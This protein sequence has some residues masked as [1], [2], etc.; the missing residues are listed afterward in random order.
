M[1][2]RPGL[3]GVLGI[4]DEH[5]ARR[6]ADLA[7]RLPDPLAPLARIAYN[8]RW[9]WYPGGKDVFSAID[10]GRWKLCGENPVRL[11]QEASGEELARA[12]RDPDLLARV[13]ALEEAFAADLRR[14]ALGPVGPERP[15]AFL[16]AEYAV[17]Q[18]LPVYSG[19]LGA[20]AGDVLKEASDRA[21]PMVAVGLL[22]RQGYFRQ[23]LDVSGWQQE[24]WIDIDPDRLPAALVRGTDGRPLT[25]TVP[26]RGVE[27]TAQIWHVAVGRVPL[28]L[29]DADRPENGR[30]ERWITS[31]L[32]V[33]DPITRLSQYALLGVGGMR[34]LAAVGI[35]P[36]LVH[37]N[38]GHAGFAALEM[39]RGEAA[40]GASVEAA[41]EAA[42]QRTVFT[43]HTPVAAGNETYSRDD[44]I[45]TLG[46][47]IAELGADPEEIVGLGRN[48]SDDHAEP[49]GVTQFSLRM[50]R[51]ANAV[52]RRHAAVAREMW[53]GLWPHRPVDAVPINY[54]TNGVHPA[55]WIGAPMR[56]LLDRHLGGDWW[57]RAG[58]GATWTALDDVPDAELWRARSEQRADLVEFVKERSGIDRLAE[59]QP[60]AEIEAAARAFDPDVLTI[61]FARRN[62]TYKR[63]RLLIQDPGRALRLLAGPYRIQLVLAGKAHPSDDDAKRV[64]QELYR[65]KDLPEVTEHVVFLHDYDLGTAARMVR[66]CDLWLNL[67]RPPLEASGTSGM[68]AVINGGLHLSVL[69]GWWAEAYDGTNGWALPGDVD[70]DAGAQDARDAGSLYDLFEQEVGPAF[71][72][73]DA[74]G[75]PRSWLTR[76]RASIRTLAP[77]FCTARMLDD[78]VERVYA[79]AAVKAAS[80]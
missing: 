70:P 36:G 24:Y 39:A 10:D 62:A 75:L 72:E 35:D 38:E 43:T 9:C 13:A 7:G 25:V 57:Q 33:G 8:Y 63:I 54:V 56:R 20:L 46:G 12:A 50:S 77:A 26:I 18:S 31:Q 66:G 1:D 5:L 65:F 40:R 61:G 4:G 68:K 80:S 15:I 3:H 60:R 52:S 42:R 64:V 45:S 19:G 58:D 28:L 69:D 34:A 27:V 67:P 21:L 30:L 55:S 76:I 74:D 79:P 49:F 59:R 17:H 11:L 16:C 6:A 71:Y 29:L 37:L 48:R 23:R 32:Y 73:R 78:Y 51:A 14:P 2:P 47:V 53:H 44:L 41:L 22:Y